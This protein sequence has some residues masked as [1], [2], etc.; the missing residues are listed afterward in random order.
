MA[1]RPFLLFDD[2]SNALLLKDGLPASAG[3]TAYLSP[4]DLPLLHRYLSRHLATISRASAL[5][6]ADHAWA[7]HRALLHESAEALRSRQHQ[8][9]VAL[10]AGVAREAARFQRGQAGRFPFFDLI[11]DSTYHPATHAV[12]S[13]LCAAA[14]AAA[15]GHDEATLFN[16]LLGGVF[17]N[18]GKLGLPAE[19]LAHDGP[20]DESEWRLMRSHPQH[21]VTLLR[22]A[23]IESPAV[24]RGAHWHH[25]HWDGHGY[26]D[27]LRGAAIPLEARCIA[28][29]D[30]YSA[31]TVDRASAPGAVPPGRCAS[32][33]ATAASSI[34]G[35]CAPL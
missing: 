31:I 25:E 14:L 1:P 35:C 7:I 28:I 20:L 24:L 5:D 15:R 30:A 23:G 33:R 21:S 8:G 32:C 16:V 22:Q 27:A 6:A 17:A 34:P 19:M 18:L 26:P 2:G 3:Q 9:G 13:A 29:G 4:A 10:V 11:S 12:A